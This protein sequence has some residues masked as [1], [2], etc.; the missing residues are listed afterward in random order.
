[1]MGYD[2]AGTLQLRRCIFII[3]IQVPFKFNDI[4]RYTRSGNEI[5]VLPKITRLL[6]SVFLD[7]EFWYL[8]E[9]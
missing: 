7:G 5:L 3:Y 4:I 6:P 8:K 9:I 1:M 2:F